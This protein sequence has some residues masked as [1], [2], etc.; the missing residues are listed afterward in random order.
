MP[1]VIYHH[2]RVLT[3]TFCYETAFGFDL[4]LVY[5]TV[6]YSIARILK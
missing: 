1:V 2:N 4:L 5:C 6:T 3:L